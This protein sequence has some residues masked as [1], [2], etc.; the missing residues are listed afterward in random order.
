MTENELILQLKNIK[1][2]GGFFGKTRKEI[3]LPARVSGRR[4]VMGGDL[5]QKK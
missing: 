4:G 5:F 2:L 3:P 1:G